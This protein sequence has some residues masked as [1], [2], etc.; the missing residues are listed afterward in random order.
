MATD[1]EKSF[2]LL[3]YGTVN[4]GQSAGETNFL[5]FFS[6]GGGGNFTPIP[7]SN[8]SS[9][10][11]KSS[12]VDVPGIY[13]F[14]VDSPDIITSGEF[15]QT[16]QHTPDPSNKTYSKTFT[17]MICNNWDLRLQVANEMAKTDGRVEICLEPSWKLLAVMDWD[18]I[19]AD[20]AC[21]Q[22]G[23][24]SGGKGFNCGFGSR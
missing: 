1:G 15:T 20:V 11:M 6:A 4:M 22:L 3:I 12:N 13:L 23:F 16:E 18:D 5:A 8:T 7:Q 9:D 17:G 24:L 19:N 2:V 14:Q 21:K 10:L